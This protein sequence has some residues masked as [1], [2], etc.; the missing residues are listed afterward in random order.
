MIGMSEFE[1]GFAPEELVV[2]RLGHGGEL[3]DGDMSLLRHSGDELH[4]LDRGGLEAA[5]TDTRASSWGWGNLPMS[6]DASI[7]DKEEIR[8]LEAEAHAGRGLG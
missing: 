5:R 7:P 1:R 3:G 6:R 4:G 8:V 2:V